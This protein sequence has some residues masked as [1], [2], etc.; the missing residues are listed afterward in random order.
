VIP[1]LMLRH[2][3]TDWNEQG[4]VQGR[5][6]RP[7]S[8]AGRASLAGRG[9]PEEWIGADC[10]CSPL[11]RARQ[12]A[13]CLGL[14]PRIDA[15]LVEMHW[16]DWE[17]CRIA[18]LRREGGAA[19]A[20]NEARGL[21]FCPPGGE[22]PRDVQARLMPLLAELTRP[23]IIVTHKGVLRAAY[24]LAS[25]WDMTGRPLVRLLDGCA[26]EYLLEAGGM[27]VIRLLN[28]PL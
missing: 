2:A 20:A 23:T 14:A 17:G 10:L 18:D 16:G 1:I 22:S 4:R 6:D 15:R 13:E 28:R 27:P 5:T 3:A 19:M 11:L 24:A 9:L 12:T 8:E 25:G 7:L 21:D 26:H